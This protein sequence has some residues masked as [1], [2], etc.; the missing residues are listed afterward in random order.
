MYK[1]LIRA[2]LTYTTET[3]TVSETN[4]WRLWLFERKGL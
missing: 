2:V 1:V 3:W 4:E